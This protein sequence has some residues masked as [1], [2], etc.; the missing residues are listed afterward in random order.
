MHQAEL[1]RK[2]AAKAEAAT[3]KIESPLHAPQQPLYE[4]PPEQNDSKSA[5]GF[6]DFSANFEAAFSSSRQNSVADDH[7]KRNSWSFEETPHIIRFRITTTDA[8]ICSFNNSVCVRN[9]C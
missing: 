8:D 5:F 9:Y 2:V 6:S 7:A 4:V 1:Q 3:P